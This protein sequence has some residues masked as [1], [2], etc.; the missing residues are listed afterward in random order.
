MAA[1]AAQIIGSIADSFPTTHGAS[2]KTTDLLEFS[3]VFRGRELT[4]KHR[5]IVSGL[6]RVDHLIGGGIV[7]G[8][9]SEIIGAA[10]S[11]KTSL[12]MAFAARVTR[13]EAAAWIEAGDHLDPAS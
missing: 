2:L 7:R 13:Y 5:R 12:A 1:A 10:G 8:R 11:G 4:L 9:I 6:T 3:G